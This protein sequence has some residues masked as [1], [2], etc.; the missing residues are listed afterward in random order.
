MCLWAIL[1][2]QYRSA[3]TAARKCG[4]WSWNWDWCRAI[5]FLG[6]HKWDFRCSVQ[7]CK[8]SKVRLAI[9]LWRVPY[10]CLGTHNSFKL[11]RRNVKTQSTSEGYNSQ[12]NITKLSGMEHKKFFSALHD[13]A[14]ALNNLAARISWYRWICYA[15]FWICQRRLFDK[16]QW[17]FF[18]YFVNSLP[19]P[20]CWPPKQRNRL[21]SSQQ[22]SNNAF[23]SVPR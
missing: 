4:P 5:P 19:A 21:F 17:W 16:M 7:Y 14:K 22:W 18:Q 3:Y 11:S 6:I 8:C 20:L 1:Y 10:H 23:I 13:C 12:E 9:N 2:S 15:A